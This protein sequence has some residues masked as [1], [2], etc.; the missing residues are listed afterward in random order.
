[1]RYSRHARVRM[2]ERSISEDEVL[3]VTRDPQVTFTDQKGNPCYVRQIGGRR[4]KVVV[5]LDDDQF[6]ITAIDLDD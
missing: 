6:V 1:M 3:Q 4:L 5:A 2:A